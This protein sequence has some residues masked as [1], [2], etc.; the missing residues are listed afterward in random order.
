MTA[1]RPHT[2][3]TDYDITLF[4][5]GNHCRLYQKMGSHLTEVNGEQGCTFCVYAP[6]ARRVSVIGEFN[7]WQSGIHELFPRWDRSGIWE[8]FIPGLNKGT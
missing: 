3:F 2:I 4:Q 6:S 5:G 1:V 7:H 8:G